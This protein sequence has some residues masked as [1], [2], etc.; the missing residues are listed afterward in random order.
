M[1]PELEYVNSA[2]GILNEQGKVFIGYVTAGL[3]PY[4][5]QQKPD[6][7]F[8][9]SAGPNA[10]RVFFVELRLFGQNGI[11]KHYLE[12]LRDHKDFAVEGAE[13]DYAGFAFATDARLQPSEARNLAR[14]EIRFLGEV[15]SAADLATQISAWA[16]ERLP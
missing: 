1:S 5:A 4:S 3:E 12:A 9:P 14:N 8:V 7:S 6:L 10:G 16:A 15:E 13:G 2:A 11:P